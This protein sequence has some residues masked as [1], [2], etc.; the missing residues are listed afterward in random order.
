MTR[1]LSLMP[2][3]TSIK[4]HVDSYTTLSDFDKLKEFKKF[5]LNM[6]SCDMA[7][8][9]SATIFT[10]LFSRIDHL[11]LVMP[12]MALEISMDNLPE[13]DPWVMSVMEIEPEAIPL[14]SKCEE[15]KEL[16]IS[17]DRVFEQASMR[18]MMVCK[19]LGVLRLRVGIAS[20][21]DHTEVLT[22]IATLRCQKKSSS[23]KQTSPLSICLSRH[24]TPSSPSTHTEVLPQAVQVS[25]RYT[26]RSSAPVPTSSGS[27]SKALT[28]THCRPFKNQDKKADMRSGFAL[29]STSNNKTV[30][31][32]RR[33]WDAI[34]IQIDKL[35]HLRSLSIVSEDLD[36]YPGHG[37]L[38]YC[39]HL[40]HL[41]SLILAASG[42]THAWRGP[43]TDSLLARCPRL[44]TLDLSCLKRANGEAIS[45]WLE[46]NHHEYVELTF[47]EEDF[48]DEDCSEYEEEV[49]DKKNEN[50]S[51]Y[52][53]GV[54][55][56]TSSD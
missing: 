29:I 21:C 12:P 30:E 48:D 13:T 27:A 56:E 33:R 26:G 11:K 4:L 49:D 44:R 53:H 36:E 51:E 50:Y 38:Q 25:A 28:S 7:T 17:C 52:D 46:K 34:F 39:H 2:K 19:K 35:E 1:A 32:M 24:S 5:E 23:S 16:V 3:L 47:N 9:L 54:Y 31:E 40:S 20:L 42:P 15:F 22:S 37:F 45:E 18:P 8:R 55:E 14:S 6:L 10:R 41:E 43:Q